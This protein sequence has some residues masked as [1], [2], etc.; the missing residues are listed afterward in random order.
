[1]NICRIFCH[2]DAA[3]HISCQRADLCLAQRPEAAADLLLCLII[4]KEIDHILSIDPVDL[5]IALKGH[6]NQLPVYLLP[7]QVQEHGDSLTHVLSWN[8]GAPI[9]G[10]I[11]EQ[12]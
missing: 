7:G 2:E 6:L 11:L 9:T 4:Y 3:R 1:M 12:I 8:V 10:Y 5:Y